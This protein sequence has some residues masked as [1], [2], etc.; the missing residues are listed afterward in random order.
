MKNSKTATATD[1]QAELKRI[2]A[3][4]ARLVERARKDPKVARAFLRDIG[5][6]SIM[7]LA[8]PDNPATIASDS[9]PASNSP[10]A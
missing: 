9:R 8:D 1:A 10:E 3:A 2:E 7:G 6:Y 4:S 5:Y